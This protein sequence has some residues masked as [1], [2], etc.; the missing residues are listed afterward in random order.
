[1]KRVLIRARYPTSAPESLTEAA[2]FTLESCLIPGLEK[3]SG[4]GGDTSD[5]GW[6][7]TDARHDT[8]DRRRRQLPALWTDG[9]PALP[10]V[11][12][13]QRPGGGGDAGRIRGAGTQTGA[14]GRSRAVEPV[15]PDRDPRQL[16]SPAHAA[17][18]P[19][20]RGRA[21]A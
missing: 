21:R 10:G 9:L 11:A 15:V 20:A 17:A 5:A 1:M 2:V 3:R 16:E 6:C 4:R 8:D 18:P 12:A 7:C 14:P 13:Q 19:G